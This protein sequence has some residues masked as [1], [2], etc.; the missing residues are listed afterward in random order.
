MMTFSSRRCGSLGVLR[1]IRDIGFIRGI[2]V[3]KAII[4]IVRVSRVIGVSI[5][6]VRTPLN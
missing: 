5:A 4:S 1:L 6:Y 2:G 3:I